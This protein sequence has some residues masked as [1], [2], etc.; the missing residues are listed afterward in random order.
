MSLIHELTKL[1]GVMAAGEYA[2]RGDRFNYEGH[3]S[4]EMARMA[5]IMCRS[6]TMAL[7]MQVDMLTQ[8]GKDCGCSPAQGWLV[9]GEKYTVVVRANYFCFID[10]SANNLNAIVKYI[11]EHVDTQTGE[12]V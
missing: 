1:P 2:Y 4:E 6:T 9:S 7:H 5:S 12:L 8:L 3:L 10:N 11:N